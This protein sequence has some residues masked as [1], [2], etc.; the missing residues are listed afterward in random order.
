MPRSRENQ[1][2]NR[3]AQNIMASTRPLTTQVLIIM[4][5]ACRFCFVYHDCE[6]SVAHY[7]HSLQCTV[8]KTGFLKLHGT[9]TGTF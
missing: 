4:R 1:N 6:G 9:F 5:F 8:V 2:R 3:G 7:A